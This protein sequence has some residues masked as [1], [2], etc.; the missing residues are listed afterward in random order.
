VL[1]D[2]LPAE[3]EW[4]QPL[5]YKST[6]CTTLTGSRKCLGQIP[7]AQPAPCD[8][9]Q[10]KTKILTLS[11]VTH[12]DAVVAGKHLPIALQL[13]VLSS[14]GSHKLKGTNTPAM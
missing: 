7:Q 3:A 1:R 5:K 10:M 12:P 9:C 14:S 11:K 6:F 4:A 2:R 8:E 13:R